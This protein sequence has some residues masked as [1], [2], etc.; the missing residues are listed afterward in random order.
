M[1]AAIQALQAQRF[2]ENMKSLE[3]RLPQ[4]TKLQD[5]LGNKTRVF[6]ELETELK[7]NNIFINHVEHAPGGAFLAQPPP[8]PPQGADPAAH[9]LAL[10]QWADGRAMAMSFLA[11]VMPQSL[12]NARVHLVRQGDPGAL[13]ASLKAAAAETSNAAKQLLRLSLDQYMKTGF[14]AAEAAFPDAPDKAVR[15]YTEGFIELQNRGLEADPAYPPG[16]GL[17]CL[18]AAPPP[19]LAHQA[20]TIRLQLGAHP[21]TFTEVAAALLEEAQ[22]LMSKGEWVRSAPSSSSTGLVTTGARGASGAAWTPTEVERMRAQL[23]IKDDQLRAAWSKIPCNFFRNLPPCTDPSCKYSHTLKYAPG[24]STDA[25]TVRG[26]RGRRGGGRRGQG[27]RGA[28]G[29][30]ANVTTHD[31]GRLDFSNYDSPDFGNI[32]TH[33]N[34]RGSEEHQRKE[35]HESGSPAASASVPVPVC[36][37]THAAGS[38]PRPPNPLLEQYRTVAAH[39]GVSPCP[40]R[41]WSSLPPAP[42]RLVVDNA[43]T[44]DVNFNRSM[45]IDYVPN[46]AGAIPPMMMNSAPEPVAGHGTVVYHI[47]CDP[48]ILGEDIEFSKVQEWVVFGAGGRSRTLT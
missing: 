8:Q 44:R 27:G 36:C 26:G 15:R 38:P 23:A 45:F 14:A 10:D 25:P 48:G 16:E 3:R 34:V 1:A 11:N 4:Q 29:A 43:A 18:L 5:D 2:A 19:Q 17:R 7:K 28:P 9:Q 39:F 13:F 37:V 21:R 22:L 6:T 24:T 33:Y 31:P 20:T 42:W 32:T 12:Y 30:T 46:S 35:E 40:P 41:G 47:V